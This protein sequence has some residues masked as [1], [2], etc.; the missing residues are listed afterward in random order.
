M[1]GKWLDKVGE[2]VSI[3]FL[4]NIYYGKLVEVDHNIGIVVLDD[5]ITTIESEKGTKKAKKRIE[6]RDD[7]VFSISKLTEDEYNASYE[8]AYPLLDHA[9]KWRILV[10]SKNTC[11][12]Y[13]ERIYSG[14]TFVD[15]RPS[16]I[17]VSFPGDEK[18][19]IIKTSKKDDPHSV[20]GPFI[21][22][23][24]FSEEKLDELVERLNKR[25]NEDESK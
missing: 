6:F 17:N 13:I 16:L 25:A 8:D 7:K 22:I 4:E 21:E 10:T 11:A 5:V 1:S 23:R 2:Y 19:T 18:T 9:G 3:K 14:G 24:P 20:R 15:L 12:G